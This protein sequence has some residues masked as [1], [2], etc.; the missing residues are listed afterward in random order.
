MEYNLR[1]PQMTSFVRWAGSKRLL[2]PQ[3]LEF[4]RCGPVV[5]YVEPFAGSAALFFS[6]A[7]G[8]ALL[9]DINEEL[10][11]TYRAVRLD[12]E[13]VIE[14]F[15]RLPDGKAAY[16]RIRGQD[17]RS[18]PPA[19]KAARF[20]YLNRYCFNGIYRTNKAGRFNVPYGPPR[21]P[22]VGFEDRLRAGAKV[23]ASAQLMVCDFE[24][25]VA[26]VTRGDF[27]YL[28]PPYAVDERRIFREYLPGSF[29]TLDLPRLET[30]LN[31]IDH[32]GATFLLSYAWCR[33]GRALADAW[34]HRTVRSR[35]NVAG[36]AG[37]RRL[38]EEV[39]IS[40]K[41]LRDKTDDD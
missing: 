40:N 41:P 22:L 27:V 26:R 9:A 13:L 3:L 18:M 11:A 17:S 1:S 37:H 39:L 33:E 8:N 2:L 30:A 19:A 38:A 6:L 32:V 31:H 16:Y 7:P 15:R 14:C 4:V 23:L 35:R 12:V 20:L 28:D 36:F 34:H 10:M 21:K 24:E 5:R 29:S 25:V